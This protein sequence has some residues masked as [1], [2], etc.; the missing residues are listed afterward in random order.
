MGKG[1]ILLKYDSDISQLLCIVAV[2]KLK[3]YTSLEMCL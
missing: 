1:L 2:F 3:L